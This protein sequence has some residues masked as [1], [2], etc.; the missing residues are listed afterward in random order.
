MLKY[1]YLKLLESQCDAIIDKDIKKS[2]SSFSA[3]CRSLTRD[4]LP[5]FERA[6]IAAIS[7][8]LL[9]IAVKA[10]DVVYP[11]TIRR[12]IVMMKELLNTF[13][14][15]KKTCGDDIRRAIEINL[16]FKTQNQSLSALNVSLNEFFRLL[17]SAYF[18]NL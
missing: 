15:K 7:F 14:K 1:D 5:P 17:L 12:Q 10:K 8:S 16:D 13:F 3:V 18:A 9:D 11:D 2:K 4:F 6:D